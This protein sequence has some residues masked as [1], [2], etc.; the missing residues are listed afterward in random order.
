MPFAPS[1]NDSW[2]TALPTAET[3]DGVD[4]AFPTIRPTRPITPR[5]LRVL[6]RSFTSAGIMPSSISHPPSM[7]NQNIRISHRHCRGS[8]CRGSSWESSTKADV[9]GEAGKGSTES[10]RQD[11]AFENLG[12]E[13]QIA[14]Q[15]KGCNRGVTVVTT[16]LPTLFT[17]AP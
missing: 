13:G 6:V 1:Q 17:T 10:M 14:T 2:I 12:D 7:M 9:G 8:N 15:L 4:Y 5:S 11:H 3:S 16:D